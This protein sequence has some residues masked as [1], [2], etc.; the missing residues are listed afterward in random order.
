MLSWQPPQEANSRRVS[1]VARQTAKIHQRKTAD[2]HKFPSVEATQKFHCCPCKTSFCHLPGIL[3]LQR[4]LFH[5]DIF[6]GARKN[7]AVFFLLF[8]RAF[9]DKENNE[10]EVENCFL[11]DFQQRINLPSTLDTH[12]KFYACDFFPPYRTAAKIKL[13]RGSISYER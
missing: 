4:E 12:Q 11:I 1:L 2:F 5:R 6:S 9:N 7:F 8:H 3:S 13:N 10:K